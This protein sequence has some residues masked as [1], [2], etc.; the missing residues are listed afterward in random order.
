L[1]Q[2]RPYKR[3]PERSFFCC[4]VALRWVPGKGN[5]WQTVDNPGSPASAAFLFGEASGVRPF[6]ALNLQV[7]VMNMNDNGSDK[8]PEWMNP[9]NDRKTAYTDEEID[10][11]VED[12]LRGLGEQ[13]WLSMTS[14]Y[15]EEKTR[16]KIRAAIVKMDERNLANITTEGQVH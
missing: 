16:E 6:S 3:K 7:M 9:A 2:L 11:V 8:E 14:E 1:L 13:E 5:S 10:T 4:I 15:G 12:F